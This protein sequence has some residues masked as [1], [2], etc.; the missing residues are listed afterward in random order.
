M[1]CPYVGDKNFNRD[2]E[3]VSPENDFCPKTLTSCR[4]RFG[5]D[6]VLPFRGFPGVAKVR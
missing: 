4:K 2:N 1:T 6:G 5:E 3:E